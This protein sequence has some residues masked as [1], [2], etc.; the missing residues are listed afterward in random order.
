[1]NERNS[2]LQTAKPLPLRPDGDLERFA[3]LINAE[4]PEGARIN[5]YRLQHPDETL[6]IGVI[7]SCGGRRHPTLLPRSV[8]LKDI[9]R[10]EIIRAINQWVAAI[11]QSTRWTTELSEA[12]DVGRS[13]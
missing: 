8:E 11:S 10:Q 13:V 7:F 5:F 12:D 9:H 4:L 2:P 6:Q 1:M 3:A